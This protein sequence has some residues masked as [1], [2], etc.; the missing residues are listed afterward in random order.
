[1]GNQS[2]PK[3]LTIDHLYGEKQADKECNE[4]RLRVMH[5]RKQSGRQ[6]DRV[7]FWMMKKCMQYKTA[8]EDFLDNRSKERDNQKT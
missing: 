1:M 2:R 5:D 4:N 3:R 7:Q 8:I 6:H